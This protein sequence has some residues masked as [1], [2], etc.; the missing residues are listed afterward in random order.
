[1]KNYTEI[2]ASELLD[3]IND[4]KVTLVDVRNEDEVQRGIISG[5]M[6]IQLQLL[7]LQYKKLNNAHTVVFYCHLGIRSAHAADFAVAKGIKN[8]HNLTGGVV[9]WQKAGYTL[10]TKK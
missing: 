1:M 5:A 10:T 9:A 3:L 4:S 8:V 7:P 6:H 2:E